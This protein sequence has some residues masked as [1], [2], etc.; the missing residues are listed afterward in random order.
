MRHAAVSLCLLLYI[1]LAATSCHYPVPGDHWA[2][3]SASEIDSVEFRASH[4]YWRGYNFVATD[5]FRILSRPPFT[6]ELIYM[7]DTSATVR[8]RDVLVVEDVAVAP[9]DTSGVWVK[10]AAVAGFDAY[11]QP[12]D[13]RSGWV[14]EAVLLAGVVPDTPVSKCIHGFSD[15]RFK[16][17][18]SCLGLAVLFGLLQ[19]V[20]RRRVRLVRLFSAGSF[21]PVLLCLSVSAAAVLYQSM[22]VY[23]PA[24]WVEF[25][26]HPTLNPF[27][28]DLPPV[29]SL[30]VA[31]IWELAVVG[32]AVLYDLSR[33][34]DFADACT[35]VAVLGTA[36]L[37]L[38]L[39]FTLLL[40]VQAGYVLLPLFWWVALRRWRRGRAR[41]LCGHC[42]Q[43]LPSPGR[44]PRCGVYNEPD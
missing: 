42:G 30:F 21:Y 2:S 13:V 10:I 8:R 7:A 29:L 15:R 1:L 35:Y 17:V 3:N 24:T 9:G 41:Y 12:S 16:F 27:H 25:Y 44:C 34:T 38:Y 36:C 18:F 20:R 40:P 37:L 26:F 43:P 6:P 5:T 19:A 22:Q 4:H 31:A 39:V 14:R 23:V 28:P 33:R 32:V 11:G